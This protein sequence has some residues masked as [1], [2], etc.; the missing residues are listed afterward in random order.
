MLKL[1]GRL[2]Q[3]T[4]APLITFWVAVGI[5][6]LTRKFLPL[7]TKN[8]IDVSLVVLEYTFVVSTISYFHN[9]ITTAMGLKRHMKTSTLAGSSLAYLMIG[10][11]GIADGMK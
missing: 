1:N 10:W 5:L 3:Y 4:V 6:Q 2:L 7:P 9:R 11:K 8:K